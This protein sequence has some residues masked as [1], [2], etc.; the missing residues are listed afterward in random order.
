MRLEG[1]APAEA[2]EALGAQ[3]F[4]EAARRCALCGAEP[5][6]QA[7]VAAGE[8]APSDCPNAALFDALRQSRA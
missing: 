3:A 8:P 4:A 7:R 6:C 1:L 5:E 2:Q